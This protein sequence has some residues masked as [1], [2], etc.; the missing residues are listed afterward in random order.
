ML[1][2][3]GLQEKSVF[4]EVDRSKGLPAAP[5]TLKKLF[6]P[7]QEVL[8]KK[9]IATKSPGDFGLDSGGFSQPWNVFNVALLCRQLFDKLPDK[10][11]LR[12]QLIEWRVMRAKK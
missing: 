1:A 6:S 5:P 12:R 2:L 8:L 11:Q 10:H 3:G 9:T 4:T 7:E